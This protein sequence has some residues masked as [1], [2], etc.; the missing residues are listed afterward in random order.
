VMV[1]GFG[2]LALAASFPI[3]AAVMIVRRVGEYAL[4]R[5]GREMLFT[6]VGAEIK[7][8]SK[9]AIDTAVYHGGDL[10]AAW[11]NTAI[12]AVGSS[13]AAAVGGAAIALLWAA[14]GFAI[15]RKFDREREAEAQRAPVGRAV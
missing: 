12:V 1:A 2:L 6:V 7:Y 3:L 8:K 15:G 4:I 14:S 10:L 9:N 11:L 13:A 5:P